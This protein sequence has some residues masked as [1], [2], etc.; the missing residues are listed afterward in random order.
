MKT[1]NKELYIDTKFT[2]DALTN[3]GGSKQNFALLMCINVLIVPNFIIFS[4]FLLPQTYCL[5]PKIFLPYQLLC[6]F[7]RCDFELIGN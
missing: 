6:M 2:A 1:I 3:R 4:T 5:P 7:F